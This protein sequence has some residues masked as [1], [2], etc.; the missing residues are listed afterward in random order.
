MTLCCTVTE[1][2]SKMPLSEFRLW[3]AYRKKYGPM[4]P[5]RRFDAGPAIVAAMINNAHGGKAKPKNFMP[6]GEQRDDE[7]LV[8]GEQF[9]AQLIGARGVKVGR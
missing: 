6:Y 8:T 3:L 1:L 7:T 2:Q 5:V 4:H 9:V